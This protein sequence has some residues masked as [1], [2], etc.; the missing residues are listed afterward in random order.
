MKHTLV[1]LLLA[2]FI[3]CSNT[4]ESNE[5]V[6]AANSYL[7]GKWSGS[8]NFLDQEFDQEMGEI[9]FIIDIYSSELAVTVGETKMVNPQLIP[10]KFGFEIRGELAGPISSNQRIEKDKMIILLVMPE[11][12]RELAQNWDSN[13]HLKENFSF[14]FTM[15][16]GGVKLQK[17]QTSLT[18]NI[19]TKNI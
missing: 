13:F 12:N 3:G 9:P 11:H 10:A 17:S 1:F 19:P 15:K 14:D 7:M 6:I 16:V 2:T 5:S 18:Q 8:G 4:H